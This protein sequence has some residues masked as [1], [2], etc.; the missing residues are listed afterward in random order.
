MNQILM[1]AIIGQICGSALSVSCGLCSGITA[2]IATI[3]VIS[4][5][6]VV[7]L[8]DGLKDNQ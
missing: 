4:I 7:W 3:D 2:F 6:V 1:G 5:L 8:F